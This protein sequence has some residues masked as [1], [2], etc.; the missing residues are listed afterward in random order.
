M[1]LFIPMFQVI[2]LVHIHFVNV[3][4]NLKTS[5]PLAP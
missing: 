4:F 1:Q 2:Y 5:L 3:N